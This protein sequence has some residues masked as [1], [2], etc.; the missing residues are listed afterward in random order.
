MLLSPSCNLKQWSVGERKALGP[1]L[2]QGG[3]RRLASDD[4]Q[5]MWDNLSWYFLSES[6]LLCG[7]APWSEG[8]SLFVV[9]PTWKVVA[10]RRS[11]ASGLLCPKA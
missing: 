6:N 8:L 5:K 9:Q 3:M 7:L 4:N 10:S 2:L 11:L 1:W